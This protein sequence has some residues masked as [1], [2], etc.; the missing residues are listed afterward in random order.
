MIISVSLLQISAGALFLLW[1]YGLL[2]KTISFETK[3]PFLIWF[4]VFVVVRIVSILFSE[5]FDISVTSLWTEI[6]YYVLFFVLLSFLKLFDDRQRNIILRTI[7]TVAFVAT[8]YAL[9]KYV[10]G[11]EK[12]ISSTTAGYTTFALYLSVLLGVV[13]F[14]EKRKEIF[15]N[16]YRWSITVLFILA[17]ILFTFSRMHWVI[18]FLLIGAY[19]IFRNKRIA[20]GLG[21]IVLLVFVFTPSLVKRGTT[22][23]NPL[24]NSSGR[25][26]I[27]QGAATIA[28]E[29]PVLGFGPQTFKTVFPIQ[30][31]IKNPAGRYFIT[32]WESD[33]LRTYM[34]TGVLGILS[35]LGLFGSIFYY[36][37]KILKLEHIDVRQRDLCFGLLA[38]MV[39][40]FLTC[41]TTGFV[42]APITS[43]LFMFVLALLSRE[44]ENAFS[45]SN[46]V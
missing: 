10:F 14:M 3:S 43:H 32:S 39:A 46:N 13:L 31:K 11:F 30:N 40:F 2:S 17:G 8:L 1:L 9:G 33:F 41:F 4:G 36:G 38:G 29:H 27:W 5:H 23:L 22:L 25:T 15:T 37:R 21:I 16:S 12:R 6:I 45:N 26:L 20:I 35:F 19:G 42:A 34:E 44:Y 18:A 7:L 24:D 28:H